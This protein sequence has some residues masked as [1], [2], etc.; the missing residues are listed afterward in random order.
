MSREAPLAHTFVQL[1][2]TLVDDVGIFELLRFLANRCVEILDVAA[3]GLMLPETSSERGIVVSSSEAMH[4]LETFEEQTNEGPCPD[5]YHT[6]QLVVDLD[7]TTAHGR[8][9]LFT[10]RALASGFR[11]A[12]ALPLRLRDETIGALNLFRTRKGAMGARDV[13]AA[14]ALADVATVTILQYRASLDL[15]ILNDQ[16]KFALNS[17]IVIEQAKGIIGERAGIEMEQAF[18]LLRSHARNHGRRLADV[19]RDIINGALRPEFLY[20]PPQGHG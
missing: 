14:E 4:V 10:P 19:A 5:C 2:D 16:L 13:S 12:Y 17:R 9:P 8:W 1:T 7:L 20:V 18:S 15:R 6:G 11:S 3:A